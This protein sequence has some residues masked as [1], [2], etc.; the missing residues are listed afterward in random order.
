MAIARMIL[1]NPEIIIFDEATSQ[2]DSESEEK[3]QKAFWKAAEG[4]TTIIIA[5]RLS[6]ITQSDRILV[7]EE[8]EIIEEGNHKELS[9][10]KN[11]RYYKFWRLQT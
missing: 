5:H 10:K 3:I 8:G 7:M 2:L 11:S 4:K 9:E 6:T 1:S